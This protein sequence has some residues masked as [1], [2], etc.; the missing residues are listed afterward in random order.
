MTRLTVRKALMTVAAAGA[1]VGLIASPAAA[2]P[3]DGLVNVSVGDVTVLQ[4]VNINVVAQVAAEVCGL[5]VGPVAALAELVDNSGEATT[6][7]ISD[8]GP[9]R[10][11][12]N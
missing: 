9:V 11:F 8:Q 7:C 2:Q 4:D 10:I 6:V 5:E 3:Q 12:D 1:S